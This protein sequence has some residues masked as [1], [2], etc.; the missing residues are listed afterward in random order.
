MLSTVR[1]FK[2]IGAAIV[3]SMRFSMRQ[4]EASSHSVVEFVVKG[5][6]N[7]PKAQTTQPCSIL[8]GRTRSEGGR[9][10]YDKRQRFGESGDAVERE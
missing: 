7:R 5:H 10:S 2:L 4:V 1:S 6:A 3:D 9:L 8:G